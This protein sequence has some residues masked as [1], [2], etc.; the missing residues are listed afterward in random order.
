V[1]GRG[2]KYPPKPSGFCTGLKIEKQGV[3]HAQTPRPLRRVPLR[4]RQH[5]GHQFLIAPLL[6]AAQE[7]CG[8]TARHIMT[9][10]G[11]SGNPLYRIRNTNTDQINLKIC[12]NSR[13][14][15]TTWLCYRQLLGSAKFYNPLART[16]YIN[17]SR[18]F[19]YMGKP[20]AETLKGGEEKFILGGWSPN[21]GFI[22]HRP[23]V[24]PQVTTA[25]PRP[26]R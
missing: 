22:S 8:V 23:T 25:R 21:P 24:R 10:R 4:S 26:A 11:S 1:L 7:P 2:E 15:T 20:G 9:A 12:V 6:L 16:R 18:R 19:T 3:F 13:I 14:H 17:P 5:N